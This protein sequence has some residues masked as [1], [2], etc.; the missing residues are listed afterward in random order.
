[1]RQMRRN[2]L[3][4]VRCEVPG[5]VLARLP[6]NVRAT[7]AAEMHVASRLTLQVLHADDSN[8]DQ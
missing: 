6:A 8:H 1:M 5:H 4:D 7:D 2:P 3:G